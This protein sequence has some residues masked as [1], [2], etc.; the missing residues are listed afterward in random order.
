MITEPLKNLLRDVPCEVLVRTLDTVL[1]DYS[2]ASIRDQQ[3][4]SDEEAVVNVRNMKMIRDALW[5]VS[6]LTGFVLYAFE[7]VM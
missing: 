4:A 7:I 2:I 3:T 1:I 6:K 5:N